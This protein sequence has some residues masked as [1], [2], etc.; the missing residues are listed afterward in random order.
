M[1]MLMLISEAA[2]ELNS[3]PRTP[4]RSLCNSLYGISFEILK[5][6]ILGGAAAVIA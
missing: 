3:Q 5:H 6:P 2:P 4:L 1:A